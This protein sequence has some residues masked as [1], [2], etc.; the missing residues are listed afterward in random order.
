MSFT[1]PFGGADP[2][3]Q[4]LTIASTGANFNFTFAATTSSG[5]SWLT[6][7]AGGGCGLCPTPQSVTATVAAN[8]ALAP[9]NYNGQ[10]TVTSQSGANVVMVHVTLTVAANASAFLDNLPG[11]L[12]FSVKTMATSVT[13]QDIQVRNGGAGSL[14]WTATASTSDGGNWL[15]ISA[16]G[17]TAPSPVTVA[18]NVSNLPSGGLVPGTFT[19][20]LVFQG[21]STS[22]TIPVSVVVGDSVFR[23]INPISFTKLF[24]GADP[25]PQTLMVASTGTN[26][27]FEVSSSNATGGAWLAAST[28]GGCGLCPTPQ[29]VTSTVNSSVVLAVGTY[30]GQIVITAQGGTQDIIV[31]VTLTVAP[32][33]STFL[34]NLPGQM[35]FALKTN[36]AGFT[37]QD[38]QV[39]NGGAGSLNWTLTKSTAD[40]GN[41]LTVSTSSGTAPSVVTVG[42]SL[43]N[44]P[45]GGL[46]PGTFVG[47]LVFQTAGDSVTIPVSVVVGDSVF[48]QVN[49]INFNRVFGGADPLPQTLT[50]PSTGT[51]FNLVVASSTAT[52]GD[53]LSVSTGGGCGLCPTPQTLTVT[54]KSSPT[55][56][57]GIY[58]GQIV[59][60]S[61]GGGMAITVPVTLTVSAAGATYFDNLPGQ[62]TFTLQTRGATI[63]NQ[64][65]EIR[66]AG[67]ATLSWTATSN[68]SDGGNWLTLS[69]SS[70]TA[71]SVL[72]VGVTVANLPGGGLLAGTF[73]GEVVLDTPGNRVTIPVTVIVGDNIFNQVNGIDFTKPFGGSD[74]LPQTLTISSKGT[75]FNFVSA[76]FTATG[77]NWLTIATGAGCGL[78]TTPQTITA[79]V[80]ASP[81]LAAGTYTG[82]IVVTAQGGGMAVTIPV[83]LTVGASGGTFFDNLP[84]QVSF[85][86]ATNSGNP[87]AQTIQVDKFGGGAL[88]WTVSPSTSDAG[89]W[90]SVSP[91]GGTT[92]TTVTV[93]V[94]AG[95]LPSQGLV[96]GTFTGN[97]VFQT[98]GSRVTVPVS[99]TVGASVFVQL[100]TLTFSKSFGGANP[101]SQAVTINSTGT[102]FNFVTSSST[103]NG[104]NWLSVTTAGGCGL[105]PT[106]RVL[107][108]SITASPTLVGG[109]YTGQIVVTAQGGG[110][111]MTIPV[112]LTVSASIPA[113]PSLVSP[114]NGATG[115]S[116]TPTLTWT[117]VTGADSYDVYLGTSSTPPFVT[118]TTATSFAAPALVSNTQYSWRVVAKNSAGATTSVTFSFTTLPAPSP[119]SI[120][121]GGGSGLTQSFVL[122]F[123]DPSGFQNLHVVD[124]LVNRVLDGRQACY[125]AFVPAS[126][127]SG[128]VF[129]VDDGG[130]AG[131]PYAG[132]VLPGSGTVANSQYSISGTG[133]SVSGSGNTLTL[134]L[135]IT[136]EAAFTG[137]RVLY[138]SAQDVA[139]N[140]S[141]WFDLG[142]WNVPGATPAGT[143]V[144]GM[145]PSR[146]D[147]SGQTYTFNFFDSNGFADIGVINVLI[148]NA[149]DGRQACFLAF[150]PSSATTG[151]VFLVDD[152]GDA[153]GPFAGG[154]TLP[155][156]G[157]ASNS[158]CTINGAGSSVTAGGNSL[159]LTLA[160]TFTPLFNGNQV[161]FLAARNDAAHENSDWQPVGSVTIH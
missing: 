154:L 3:P 23:Q 63:T 135:V 118:N 6:V 69:A 62:L 12:S 136:F 51:N 123:T 42:V 21:N 39:R 16:A 146:S 104:G 61:Q 29:S 94:I 72:S 46:L 127:T 54:I 96:P 98:A 114:G 148:N 50:I 128:S 122:T 140:N 65:L 40:G 115:V 59:V 131:G 80:N 70:G 52:G 1:K 15:T 5:G 44:L 7:S 93:S 141:G 28:G 91:L 156:N 45:G 76:S 74:P 27:N 22:T 36:G 75:A 160:I 56:A 77:G 120:V 25:L 137:N 49:A 112:L 144:T 124:L 78:C 105:C 73:I 151:S 55:L 97:L 11:Q 101:S 87:P 13:S 34:D 64:D 99:V 86:I 14:T 4:V 47:E 133:S 60:T 113:A 35:S 153:G 143:S 53:W 8:V 139:G 126:A 88:N 142:T 130:D 81:T 159:T 33:G 155:S 32:A 100:G 68:T 150:V 20:Q 66:N 116:T 103:G 41:W 149:I 147:G 84:G 10:I 9:G 48:S 117:S 82:E 89:N 85:S 110:M 92:P 107:T 38:V 121:P 37:S 111:A 26:F 24:G 31:P 19:G 102:N 17:G 134:T 18:V 109:T 90:L 108:A 30:T 2:L 57:V 71:P 132:M 95:S 152:A 145:S 138:L 158:R 129:L 161:F 43:A 106:P 58:T 119:V 83:T 157:T 125:I 79:T 67:S